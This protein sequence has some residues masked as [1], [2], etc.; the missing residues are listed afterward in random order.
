MSGE[1]APDTVP[2]IG[3]C[4][5]CRLTAY[6]PEHEPACATVHRECGGV[7]WDVERDSVAKRLPRDAGV[8]G[9]DQ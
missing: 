2:G 9:G 6:L 5:H 4:P 1:R 8:I 7:R 3:T